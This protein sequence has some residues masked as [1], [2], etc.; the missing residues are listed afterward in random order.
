MFGL[1]TTTT[2]RKRFISMHKSNHRNARKVC[3]QIPVMIQILDVKNLDLRYSGLINV[4]FTPL[5]ATSVCITAASQAE[6]C[7]S[8]DWKKEKLL[9]V[10]IKVKCNIK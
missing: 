1:R 8:I 7:K 9:C 3:F 5:W 6:D 10:K 4:W 2:S